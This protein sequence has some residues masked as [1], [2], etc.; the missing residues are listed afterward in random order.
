M[1]GG[2]L[3]LDCSHDRNGADRVSPH[4]SC[5]PRISGSGEFVYFISTTP[6]F[7][8][9]SAER[10]DLYRVTVATG[11]IERASGLRNTARVFYGLIGKTIRILPS[12]QTAGPSSAA[13]CSPPAAGLLPETVG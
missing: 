12:V 3:L 6:F 1:D 5:G 9:L 8:T 11:L 10:S 2:S 4:I 13:G 7:E